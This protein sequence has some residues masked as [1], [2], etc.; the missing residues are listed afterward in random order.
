MKNN[1]DKCIVLMIVFVWF[2][3]GASLIY[4]MGA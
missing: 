4:G 3:I 2:L 1:I